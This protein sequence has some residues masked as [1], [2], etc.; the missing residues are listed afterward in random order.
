MAH[1]ISNNSGI[2]KTGNPYDHPSFNRPGII[3]TNLYKTCL[4]II[5]KIPVFSF[6]NCLVSKKFRDQNLVR[7]SCIPS[8]YI[9]DFSF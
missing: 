7:S 2:T 6:A 8:S 5:I 3:T 4:N 9:Y 1:E